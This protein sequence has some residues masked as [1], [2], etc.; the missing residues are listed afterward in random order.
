V[1]SYDLI[2]RTHGGL[3]N[4]LFQILYGRLFSDYM[5]F[6][7]KEIHDLR[8]PH[9]FNRTELLLRGEKPTPWQSFVSA[10][11]IPKVLQRTVARIE[12]PLRFG[13]TFYLDG[14]FQSVD[15]YKSFAEKDL[16]RHLNKLANE[17]SIGHANLDSCL[18]HLRV[19]DFFKDVSTAKIHVLDRLKNTPIGA[20]VMTNDESLLNEPDIATFIELR[21]LKLVTT[22]GM[23]AEDVLRNMARYR[24]IE[25]N[26]STLTF[27]ASVLGGSELSLKDKSL[28]DCH[29]FLKKHR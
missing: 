15:S 11:R 24:R 12:K 19:G 23:P 16:K 4:Q 13:S 26:D 5:G 22:I 29:N 7:L 10:A 25:A 18:V 14:Y 2:L 1:K 6:S 20:H 27:W 8:Y 28:R 17:L 21:A 3:G 9:A